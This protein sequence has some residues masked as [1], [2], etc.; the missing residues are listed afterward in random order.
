MKYVKT[1]VFTL[2]LFVLF[3]MWTPLEAQGSASNLAFSGDEQAAY[4]QFRKLATF[5][6]YVFRDLKNHE[7]VSKLDHGV[8]DRE[9]NAYLEVDP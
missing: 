2:S 1:G 7:V 6:G 5:E 9:G 4:R 3:W 8:P